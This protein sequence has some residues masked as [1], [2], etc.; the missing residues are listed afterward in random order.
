MDRD[1]APALMSALAQPTRLAVF[2]LLVKRGVDGMNAS[3]IADAVAVPRNLMSAH[4]AVLAKAGLVH[5][6][7]SGRNQ[8]YRAVPARAAELAGFIA[9]L[10]ADGA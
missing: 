9:R 6:T 8:T 3:D 1:V 7:R 4:L 2:S 10:A 5:P